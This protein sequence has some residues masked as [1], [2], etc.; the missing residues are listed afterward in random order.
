MLASRIVQA[1]L[2][3]TEYFWENSSFMSGQAS[4]CFDLFIGIVQAFNMSELIL[5][6]KR[7]KANRYRTSPGVQVDKAPDDWF[8]IS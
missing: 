6:L 7:V 8:S 4:V 3:Y 5:L 1:A 2:L